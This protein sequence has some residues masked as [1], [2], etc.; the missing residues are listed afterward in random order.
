MKFTQVPPQTRVVNGKNIP[1]PDTISYHS[2]GKGHSKTTRV[3]YISDDGRTTITHN[4]Y[5]HVRDDGGNHIIPNSISTSFVTDKSGSIPPRLIPH[6]QEEII[7]ANRRT[8][9]NANMAVHIY[10]HVNE[11]V[12]KLA[13]EHG[14]KK[15]QISA[16]DENEEN[17]YRKANLYHTFLKKFAKKHG[18]FRYGLLGRALRLREEPRKPTRQSFELDLAEHLGAVI[19]HIRG[20]ME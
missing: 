18:K 11:V 19:Q 6:N 5:K 3:Q 8:R 2:D 16:A 17:A 20:R 10:K 4:I 14:V 13:A 15:W 7:Q 12:P 1:A 9:T